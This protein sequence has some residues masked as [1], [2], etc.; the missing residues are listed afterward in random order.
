MVMRQIYP[1]DSSEQIE[2]ANEEDI[3]FNNFMRETI[4]EKK[5]KQ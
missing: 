1:D 5:Q 2:N 4:K 3:G